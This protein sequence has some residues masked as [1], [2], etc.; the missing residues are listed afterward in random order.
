MGWISEWHLTKKKQHCGQE[1]E[2]TK[3]NCE[4]LVLS[5]DECGLKRL[6]LGFRSLCLPIIAIET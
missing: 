4:R 5:K 1:E 3:Y 2:G 6:S